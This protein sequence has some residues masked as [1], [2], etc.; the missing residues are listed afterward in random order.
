MPRRDGHGKQSKQAEAAVPQ[1]EGGGQYSGGPK[2]SPRCIHGWRWKFLC[3]WNQACVW[4]GAG[5]AAGLVHVGHGVPAGA[6]AV[7]LR[8]FVSLRAL[9]RPRPARRPGG[10]GSPAE[11]AEPPPGPSDSN[12]TVI[13]NCTYPPFL[14]LL[15]LGAKGRKHVGEE[16]A[17]VNPASNRK[18]PKTCWGALAC[19]IPSRQRGS[20]DGPPRS[21]PRPAE[22]PRRTRTAA[23]SRHALP[24]QN[25][26]KY[27]FSK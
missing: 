22:A 19:L 16:Q 2:A 15:R 14:L 8:R 27:L 26:P 9:P 13:W 25:W 12:C 4:G 18:A 5:R 11:Q 6:P 10:A 23:S 7:I 1:C 21:T 24:V 20:P 17:V 3:S